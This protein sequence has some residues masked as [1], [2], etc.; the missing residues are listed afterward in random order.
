M[1]TRSVVASKTP[2]RAPSRRVRPARAAVPARGLHRVAASEL[3]ASDSALRPTGTFS[4]LPDHATWQ[5]P[6]PPAPATWC[7]RL[8]EEQAATE[9]N[10]ARLVEE[11]E[12][13]VSRL[14]DQVERTLAGK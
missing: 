5:M 10:L 8:S 13:E 11:L 2:Y 12:A 14:S 1:S 9:A 3:G 4:L 7:W 6:T